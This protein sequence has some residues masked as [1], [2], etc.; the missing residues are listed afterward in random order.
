MADPAFMQKLVLE[1]MITVGSS[2]VYEAKVRGD[3]FWSELDL[4]AA[5]VL[6]LSAGGAGGG[7]EGKGR[8]GKGGESR[9]VLQVAAAPTPRLL[10]RRPKA[11]V[12][13]RLGKTG[14]AGCCPSSRSRH[15]GL[16]TW[17]PRSPRLRSPPPLPSSQRG[18]GLPGGSHAR[19]ARARPLCLAEHAVQAA[20]QRV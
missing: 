17:L 4:V 3:R 2:L 11:P 19:G 10:L 20:Q 8:Q 16:T 12:P 14:A 5:N 18:T 6:S 7:R 13:F 9:A 1:Q 15:D